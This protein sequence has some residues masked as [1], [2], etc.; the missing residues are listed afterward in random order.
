MAL[1]FRQEFIVDAHVAVGGASHQDLLSLVFKVENFTTGRAAEDLK[2]KSRT[3]L[4]VIFASDTGTHILR[5]VF[6]VYINDNVCLSHIQDHIIF[7][8]RGCIELGKDTM[9]DP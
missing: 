7:Q 5:I 6:G 3:L 8:D 1:S 4:G 9:A 2:F